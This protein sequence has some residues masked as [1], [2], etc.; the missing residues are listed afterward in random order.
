LR[1]LSEEGDSDLFPTPFEVGV[2][3][4]CWTDLRT[5]LSKL[6]VEQHQWS[7]GRRFLIPKQ[8]LAFRHVTQLDPYDSLILAATIYEFGS[9]I[10][11][12]RIPTAKEIVFSCRFNPEV[13]GRLYGD[14]SNWDAFWKTSLDHSEVPETK[15]V[16]IADITDFYNQINHHVL[17]NQL[18]AANVPKAIRQSLMNLL[19]AFTQKASRG[20]P[21]GPHATRLLAEC[22]L[23]PV[24]QRLL[25]MGRPFCRY[26]DDFHF[27]CKSREE[28]VF[29]IYELASIL[30]KQGQLNLQNQKTEILD[31]AEFARRARSH[32]ID[33][34]LND[35]E[36]KILIIIRQHGGGDPYAPISLKDLS[37]EELD[38]LRPD[39]IEP[40]L[41]LYL[42]QP[43]VDYSRLGWLIRR[44][45]Q[46]GTPS[47]VE[48]LLSNIFRLTPI[49][50]DVA[51][52]MIRAGS[53]YDGSLPEI[54]ESI[55]NALDTGIISRSE[56]MQLVLINL[57]SRLPK[58]NHFGKLTQRYKS[59]GPEA[60]RE[61]VLSGC[62]AE[63]AYWIK[64]RKEEFGTADSW[65][66]RAIISG[67][68]FLPGDEG[69][70]WRRHIK[71]S[72]N[73]FEKFVVKWAER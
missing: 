35:D 70:I 73:E 62:A 20:I 5:A 34:P 43:V 37:A 23:N 57:F 12:H 17:E 28:A 67:S 69:G 13:D 33:R 48:F 24:D 1:H 38:T 7:A 19:K 63:D 44:L 16:A 32:L 27:F 68:R 22:A 4:Y 72:L 64:E 55:V 25:Q 39:I 50:G 3:N 42:D 65:L 10:E 52:Y 60:R 54:G 8:E 59:A 58:L 31:S 45:S 51:R 15:F 56:Y 36:E 49:L 47:A 40:L 14:S 21:V 11:S 66:R 29:A 71:P 30:E 18:T 9:A 53:Y 26:M 61:I 41:E 6:E 46:V 2:F